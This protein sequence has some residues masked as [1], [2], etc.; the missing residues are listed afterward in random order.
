M[1]KRIVSFIIVSVLSFCF[2]FIGLGAA[3]TC[4]HEHSSWHARY[5]TCE[6]NGLNELICDDC[7]YVIDSSEIQALGHEWTGEVMTKWPLLDASGIKTRTCVKCGEKME[8]LF[9]CNHY[10]SVHVRVLKDA[11]CTEKGIEA[12]ICDMCQKQ[13]DTREIDA[14]GHD[15]GRWVVTKDAMPGVSGSRYK[16]C[17][18]C[19]NRITESFDFS[20]AGATSLYIPGTGINQTMTIGSYSQEDVDSYKI[21]YVPEVHGIGTSDPFILG[22]KERGLGSLYKTQVGQKIYVSIDGVI[23]TYEVFLSEYAEENSTGI[24]IIGKSSGTVLQDAFGYKTLHLYTCYGSSSIGR[25]M[26]LAKKIS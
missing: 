25:W 10:S 24:L 9:K 14:L 22:H 1:K 4:N 21:V 16:E 5:A 8:R 3:F 11:T 2:L 12:D 19:K 6:K 17:T 20:M 23:E 15:Y 7:G 26:V 13:L 18:K